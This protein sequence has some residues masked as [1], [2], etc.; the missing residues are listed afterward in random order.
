MEVLRHHDMFVQTCKARYMMDSSSYDGEGAVPLPMQVK[1][2]RA[3]GSSG[4]CSSRIARVGRAASGEDWAMQRFAFQ[5][6]VAFVTGPLLMYR[7]MAPSNRDC[8][9]PGCSQA[10]A[11]L[12]TPMHSSTNFLIRVSKPSD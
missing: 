7:Q 6:P 1:T 4:K 9:C 11:Q 5:M 8:H 10:A 3:R 12:C 2:I